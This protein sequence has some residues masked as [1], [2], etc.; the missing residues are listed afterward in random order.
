[1]L[2]FGDDIKSTAGAELLVLNYGALT[3]YVYEALM[4]ELVMLVKKD[5]G[6]DN[7]QACQ[8]LVESDKIGKPLLNV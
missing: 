7:K 3:G 2:H 1:M 8:I 4:P 5:M 6:V